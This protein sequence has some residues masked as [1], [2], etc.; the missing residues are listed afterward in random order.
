MGQV[1]LRITDPRIGSELAARLPSS[2]PAE[3]DVVVTDTVSVASA[4]ASPVVFVGVDMVGVMKVMCDLEVGGVLR[5]DD[6]ETSQLT[7]V[8]TG[9]RVYSTF[10][11]DD[12]GLT[13]IEWRMVALAAQGLSP[14]RSAELISY[15]GRQIR[16]HLERLKK[17]VRRRR[18]CSWTR[19]A[20]LFPESVTGASS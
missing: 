6:V 15:S 18:D 2:I 7:A 8:A 12:L 20:P 10:G 1:I 3:S 16:R 13:E 11:P 4:V 17:R 14:E 19:L 9:S 5:P